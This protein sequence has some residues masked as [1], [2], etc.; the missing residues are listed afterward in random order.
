MSPLPTFFI[1]HGGG[2]CFFMDPPPGWPRDSWDSLA[3][4]LRRL[5][6][7]IG[8]R[9]RAAIVVSGHWEERNPTVNSGARP[10]LLFDYGGMPPHT[11]RLTWPAPGAPDVAEEVRELLERAGFATQENDRRGYDHGVFVPFKL[12]YPRADVPVVQLS[13]LASLDAAQHLAMGRAL[14]SLRYSEILIVGSGM[15]HHNLQ[16]FFSGRGNDMAEAFDAWLGDAVSDPAV[17]DASL[18]GWQGAPGGR[19]AHPRPEH[20]LP[21]MVAAG[22]APGE[23][24]E[25]VFHGHVVGKPLSGFRFG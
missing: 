15:S 14:A 1:P 21:L 4:F 3:G 11:Y 17:R 9:P 18:A 23:R 5:D 6:A 2:P 19:I 16:D 8:R 10:P 12:V 22:A 7:S 13:L 25:R 20:L 24:A